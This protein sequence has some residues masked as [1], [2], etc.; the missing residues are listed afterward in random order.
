MLTD[1]PYTTIRLHPTCPFTH[2]KL[3]TQN[4]KLRLTPLE[5]LSLFSD[6]DRVRRERMLEGQLRQR[7]IRDERVIAAMASVPRHEFVTEPYREQAYDD[8]PLPIGHGQTISQPY[9]VALMVELLQL[10]PGQTVLEVGTG[11]GYQTALLA[12]LSG[13]VY[14]I[15]RYPELSAQ[16]EATLHRL[17]YRN[18]SLEVGD[19]SLGMPAHAPFDAIAVSA[20]APEVPPALFNQL[21]EGSRLVIPIGPADAQ[22]LELIVRKDGEP[23]VSAQVPCRFVPLVGAQGYPH[24]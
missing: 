13:H 18:V 6:P 5:L 4:L 23:V 20:A 16:A 14:S 17:G 8:N 3:N 9:I 21:A 7:G 2:L 12:E 1:P 19:G 11:S 15:E 24:V 22:M 10:S